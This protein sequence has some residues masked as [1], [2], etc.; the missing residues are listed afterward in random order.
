[1]KRR[2][3]PAIEQYGV[4]GRQDYHAYTEKSQDY[5]EKP[6][7][8]REY[9]LKHHLVDTPVDRVI[10]ILNCKT[11][12]EPL[13]HMDIKPAKTSYTPNLLQVESV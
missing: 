13:L 12:P 4:I 1:M 6:S 2:D 3:Y 11:S 7:K 8:S 10:N 5:Q 9:Y